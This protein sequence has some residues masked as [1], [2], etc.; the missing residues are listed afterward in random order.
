MSKEVGGSYSRPQNPQ[1]DTRKGGIQSLRE[2]PRPPAPPPP[3]VLAVC[4]DNLQMSGPTLKL[5]YSTKYQVSK[6]S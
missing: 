3:V 4:V 2:G 6:Y 1:K 5:K